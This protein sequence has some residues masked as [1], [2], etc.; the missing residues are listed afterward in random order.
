MI[1]KILSFSLL[2]AFVLTI[3]LTSFAS[4]PLHDISNE[5]IIKN[6]TLIKS[7][8]Y[9]IDGNEY[10]EN[11]YIYTEEIP[12][13]R[14][15]EREFMQIALSQISP[16]NIKLRYDLPAEDYQ[17]DL[18]SIIYFATGDATGYP[19]EKGYRLHRAIIKPAGTMPELEYDYLTAWSMDPQTP[20]TPQTF[21]AS[22]NGDFVRYLNFNGYSAD[23]PGGRVGTMFEYYYKGEYRVLSNFVVDQHI[24][25]FSYL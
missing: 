22:G 14:N 12:S 11:V 21:S 3:N 7:D 18:K 2:L 16:T 17:I 10:R 13:S 9:N 15:N 20:N 23:V 24:P 4:K 1:K 19:G 25:T 8:I 5:D 6:G